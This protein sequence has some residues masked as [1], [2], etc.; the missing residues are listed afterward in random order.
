M[1]IS[2]VDL[3][4]SVKQQ[5]QYVTQIIHFVSGEKRTFDGIIVDSIRQGQFTKFRLKNGSMILINDKNVLMIEVFQ[6]GKITNLPESWN[7]Y[8]EVEANV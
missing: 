5:G 3:K 4:S 8:Q 7:D 2:D 6:E 1:K